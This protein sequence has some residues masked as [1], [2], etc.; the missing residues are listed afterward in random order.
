MLAAGADRREL[1]A[2]STAWSLGR[3][4]RRRRTALR[5]FARRKLRPRRANGY[6]PCHN[7][8]RAWGDGRGWELTPMVADQRRS[9][10][11][12]RDQTLRRTT[13]VTLDRCG[14][15]AGRRRC[16][17]A[18]ESSAA[19]DIATDDDRDRHRA[20]GYSSGRVHVNAAGR[21]VTGQVRTARRLWR[22][23]P[24]RS[25]LGT[26]SIPHSSNPSPSHTC[27]VA[28]IQRRGRQPSPRAGARIPCGG[29]AW[30]RAAVWS[31][32]RCWCRTRSRSLP[33]HTKAPG[34]KSSI[35]PAGI[36]VHVFV[37]GFN[38]SPRPPKIAGP[39]QSPHQ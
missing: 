9:G 30:Q 28:A 14:R 16:G 17:H 39:G 20:R 2:S 32:V 4:S 15:D 33:V 12:S 7:A 10:A 21:L 27:D 8:A 22:W 23:A 34:S 35:G 3:S 18:D 24:T 5:Q 11:G 6:R 38:R 26:S 25:P 1:A 37:L 31:V 19:P 29:L 13:T 36:F